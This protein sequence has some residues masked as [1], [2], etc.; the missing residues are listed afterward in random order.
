MAGKLV[1]N[2]STEALR[3]WWADVERIAAT[4]PTLNLQGS[5]GVDAPCGSQGE[6]ASVPGPRVESDRGD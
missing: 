6:A 4:A 3:K 5:S 1:R 2:T